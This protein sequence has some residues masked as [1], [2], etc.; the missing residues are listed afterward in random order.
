MLSVD[1]DDVDGSAEEEEI[2]DDVV[3]DDEYVVSV[4]GCVGVVVVEVV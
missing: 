2:D 1:V 3:S 4:D